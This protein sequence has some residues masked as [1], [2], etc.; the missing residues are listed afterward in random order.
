[1]AQPSF[2]YY[3]PE[4]S[5]DSRQHALFTPQ[6]SLPLP[7]LQMQQI[8]QPMYAQEVMAHQN[9]MSERPSSAGSQSFIPT[10]V[11][12]QANMTPIASPR[13]MY[14]K[15]TML[16]TEGRAL[17]VDTQGLENDGYAYPATP[18]LSISGST[19]S[20]PPMSSGVLPTPTNA[21]FFGGENIEGVKEGCE[22]EVQSE[23]LAGEDWARLGS[24]PLTPGEFL[25]Q[26]VHFWA[27]KTKY[28]E[29][30]CRVCRGFDLEVLK[31]RFVAIRVLAGLAREPPAN[32]FSV[33]P[34][35]FGYR[36]P[37][38]RPPFC[39]LSFAFPFPFS[40]STISNFR[41]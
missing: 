18:P 36:Q 4:M 28:L 6:P 10:S 7:S 37:S 16:F 29:L 17:A 2:F 19:I 23:I 14:H 27:L 39:V 26:A 5:A 21:V 40:Y 11:P 1:M 41:I 32:I 24:P 30:K 3:N 22:G 12:T 35:P 13:P 31:R 33:H 25:N 20:S 15:P 34:P 38:V 8:Q 9:M